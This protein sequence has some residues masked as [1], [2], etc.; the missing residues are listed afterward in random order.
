MPNADPTPLISTRLHHQS[1]P[2]NQQYRHNNYLLDK[3]IG[4]T[5]PKPT[6]EQW[7]NNQIRYEVQ[8]INNVNYEGLQNPEYLD[9][10]GNPINNK[11]KIKVAQ[12]EDLDEENSTR[13]NSNNAQNKPRGNYGGAMKGGT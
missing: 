1:K 12:V 2:Q 7:E 3:L 8:T 6:E 5:A 13:Q 9:A 10:D 11:D 4:K